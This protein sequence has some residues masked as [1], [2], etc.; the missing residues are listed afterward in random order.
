MC[1]SIIFNKDIYWLKNPLFQNFP[2]GS[3][4]KN[5]LPMQDSQFQSLVQEDPTC[6]GVTKRVHHNHWACALESGPTT[7]EARVP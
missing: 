2:G 7:T 6:Q 5:P 1:Y 4:V 3:V